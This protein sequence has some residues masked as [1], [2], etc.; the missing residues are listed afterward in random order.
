[1]KSSQLFKNSILGPWY[2]HPLAKTLLDASGFSSLKETVMVPF[3]VI[4]QDW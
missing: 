3:L 4:R 2:L 1:M